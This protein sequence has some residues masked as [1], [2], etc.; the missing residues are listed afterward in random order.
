M[1]YFYNWCVGD[2]YLQS[3]PLTK[4]N[5]TKK[6]T[7]IEKCLP[8]TDDE[9][10]LI[11]STSIYTSHKFKHPY[12]Y[13]L[14]LLYLYTGARLEELCQMDISDITVYKDI[15]C[16]DITTLEDESEDKQ[17]E[18]K[19]STAPK[20]LK[21]EQSKR[22][23]PIHPELIELGFF[24]YINQRK[25]LK[26]HKIFGGLKPINGKYG[27]YPS[28]WFNERYKKRFGFDT[29]N[30]KVLNSFRHTMKSKMED[31]NFEDY[32]IKAVMGH[33]LRDATHG[34]YGQRNKAVPIERAMR[35]I[36][37]KEFTKSIKPWPTNRR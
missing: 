13:W 4:V 35:D 1:G 12:Y 5:Q 3:N 10:T 15:N 18:I 29:N 7:E 8:F 11:F 37:F 25:K 9:L 34:T 23:M 27:N 20:K 36:S 2:H 33:S 30:E 26:E 24:K 19:N 21:N 32:L 6:N 22:L 31:A 17:H 14:P 28:S 16:F